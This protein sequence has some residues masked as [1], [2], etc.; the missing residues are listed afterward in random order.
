MS[1]NPI[2]MR[3]TT[4]EIDSVMTSLAFY[5]SAVKKGSGVVCLQ[6]ESEKDIGA[7][8]ESIVSLWQHDNGVKIRCVRENE[9]RPDTVGLCPKCWISWEVIDACGYPVRPVKKNFY[10]VC[11]E[12]FW[13]A[14]Q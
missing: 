11:Q 10:N 13:L 1:E 9:L 12:A 2:E 5:V 6:Q 14:M 7:E 4:D 3:D 8:V